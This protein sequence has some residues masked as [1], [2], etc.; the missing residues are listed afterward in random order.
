MI[1]KESFRMQNH[2]SELSGQALLF[3]SERDNVMK[4]KEEHLRSKSNPNAQDE[5][6]EVLR[7]TEMVPDKVIALYLDILSEREKLSAAISKAKNSADID[8]DSAISIN[9]EKQYAIRQFK[10]LARLK[11]SEST[12]AGRDYLINTEG[13]QTPYVYT[14]KAVNTIDF[15]RESLRGMIKRLQRESDEVSSKIDLINVTLEVDYT[16]KY[17]MD[18]SF[19]D[20]YEKFV[21]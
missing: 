16:P 3:L 13:N 21:G 18:E 4:V 8:I 7:P 15:D 9:K 17:D 11:S 20:A 19:E 6:I 14:V 1:L 5:T 12:T 2:L 10:G